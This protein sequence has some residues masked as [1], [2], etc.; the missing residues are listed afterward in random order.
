MDNTQFDII[1][2]PESDGSPSPVR[3]RHHN[4][5]YADDERSVKLDQHD[6]DQE[7]SL[8]KLN[9]VETA[10]FNKQTS[11][12]ENKDNEIMRDSL[13]VQ[14]EGNNNEKVYRHTFGI[15]FHKG[16][17]VNQVIKEEENESTSKHLGDITSISSPDK[18][19]NDSK[20]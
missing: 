13:Y 6:S 7:T 4:T 15:D 3:N 20:K 18:N 12:E 17:D 16:P 10:H 5:R 11:E 14:D 8:L 2:V 1:E 19:I 9:K